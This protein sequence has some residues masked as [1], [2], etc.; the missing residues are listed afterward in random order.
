MNNITENLKRIKENIAAAAHKSG[1]QAADITIVAVTK[2]IS[3]PNLANMFETLAENGISHLG[4]NRVQELIEKQ[5]LM[6]QN[7][8]W[9]MIGNLQRN[10]VKYIVGQVALIQSVTGLQLAQEISRIAIK[11]QVTADVLIE[12]NIAQEATK[13][14]AM[15]QEAASLAAAVAA[16]PNVTLKGLMAMAPFTATAEENR[17]YFRQMAELREKIALPLPILSMGMTNDYEVA[18]EEGANMVRIGTAIFGAVVN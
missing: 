17:G 9:H 10:K 11:K 4:E 13:H 2:T 8:N 3:P 18:I 6:P 14:G 15:P 12:I 16:L 1:R 7:I 5:P